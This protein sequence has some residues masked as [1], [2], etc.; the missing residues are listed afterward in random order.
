M[1]EEAVISLHRRRQLWFPRIEGSA[2]TRF[3]GFSFREAV[4]LTAPLSP[5]FLGFRSTLLFSL[6]SIDSRFETPWFGGFEGG[7][8]SRLDSL[9][10]GGDLDWVDGFV[11]RGFF[12]GATNLEAVKGRGVV[13]HVFLI[14]EESNTWFGPDNKLTRVWGKA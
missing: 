9:G 11:A 3:V 8:W 6:C 10:D 5:V 14:G 12:S 13:K 7:V 4:A 1:G 2:S